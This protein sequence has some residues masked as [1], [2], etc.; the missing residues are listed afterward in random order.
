MDRAQLLQ[1]IKDAGIVGAGGA[2]FPTG[3]KLSCNAEVV[4]GNGAECEPLLRSDRLLMENQA[5][6]IVAGLKAAM[7]VA[8]A[9]K[10]YIALK[11][12]YKKAVEALSK[13]LPKDIELLLMDSYY[14]AGDEQQIVYEA[15]GRVVPTGGLPIDVGAVVQNVTTLF[16]IAE[17]VAGR[18][19]IERYVTV[20]GEV[21]SPAVFK[22]PLGVTVKSLIK[23]AGG[24]YDMSDYCVIIGGPMMGRITTDLEEPIVKT[25][26]GILVFSKCHP[27]ISKK[28][29]S[30]Q[31]DLKLAKSICCQ[32]NFCTQLCPRNALGLKVEPHKVMRAAA[33][34]ISDI[35]DG[36]GIFSCCDCGLCT[37]YA[38]NFSLAPSRMMQRRKQGMIQSGIKPQKSVANPVSSNINDTKVPVS[39]LIARL[40]L[41]KYDR[42]LEIKEIGTV[43]KVSLP[44]KMHIGAPAKP[45]VNSGDHIEKGQ[46][47]AEADKGISANVHA[48]IAGVV[49]VTDNEIVIEG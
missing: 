39:R 44:L 48:S 32:C 45:L 13:V 1:K 19:V 34:G 46:K 20:N 15:T 47:I 12:K 37:F 18:P 36:N 17:A 24:P 7:L 41:S 5:G 49:H 38:C 27:L 42:D 26:G 40:A 2:G 9:K 14:P 22:T 16:N 10:G 28:T 11:K 21:D 3:I 6:K 8:G 31:M 30:E 25:T 23:A 4:I 43:N 33:N 29:G 35:K